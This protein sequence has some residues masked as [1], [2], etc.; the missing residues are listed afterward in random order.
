MRQEEFVYQKISEDFS[1]VM[2]C[3]STML[4]ELG[5]TDLAQQMR[6]HQQRLDPEADFHLDRTA[7]AYS[8]AFQLLSMVEENAQSQYRRVAETH[9]EY[10][11]ESGLWRRILISLKEAGLTGEQIATRLPYLWVEPVLTAHPTEAK[12]PTVLDHHREF[13]L[14]LLRRENQMWTPSEQ[15][16]I[17]EEIITI[18][19]RLWRTGEIYLEKPRLEQELDNILHYLRNVFPNILPTLDQRLREAW[20]E[21]GFDPALLDDPS[22]FPRLSFGNWVGGDRDGHPLVTAEVTEIC[23]KRLRTTALELLQQQLET[24]RNTLSLAEHRQPVPTILQQRITELQNALGRRG[25]KVVY[26]FRREPWRQLVELFC[27]ALPESSARGN[28]SEFSYQRSQDLL[29]DLRLLRESLLEVGAGRMARQEVDPVI[30]L[31]QTFGFHLAVLDI[32]QNSSFHDQAIEQLLETAGFADTSFGIW[33]EE[34]RLNFLEQELKTHRPFALSTTP[35]GP[36]ATAIRECYGVLRQYMEAH[37]EQGIGNFIVSMTRSATDLLS[38]Y[39]LANEA[40]LLRQT[41]DGLICPIHIV[42]LFETI[43]DLIASPTIMQRFLA[44]PLT[45]RSLRYQQQ[46]TGWDRPTQQIMVG[47]SDSNKDGGILASQWS[48]FRAQEKLLEIGQAHGISLRFF[49][50]RGGTISRGAGPTHRFLRALPHGSIGGNLRL[51]EQGE[52]I[53]QKYANLGTAHYQLEMLVAGTAGSSLLQENQPRL[54][55]PMEGVM[56]DLMESSRQAYRQLLEADG[57][58][59]FFREATPIDVI[60]SSRIGSR[61]S[62]R[63]GQRSLSDLRAIPWVF[64]WSQSRFFLSSWY[65]LGTAL[66]QLREAQPEVFGRLCEENLSWHPFHYLTSNVATSLAMV[67]EDVTAQYAKLV[68]NAEVRNRLLLQILTE[69]RRSRSMLEVLYAGPLEE[70]RARIQKSIEL[71]RNGLRSLHRQQLDLLPK[72][73]GLKAEGYDEE[74]EKLL[75]P[76]LIT[77]NAIASGLRTTG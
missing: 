71:R 69:Y 8:I 16:R 28:R 3:F 73:R 47:Y 61:P 17:R 55:N 38:V 64:A 58:I 72:W 66:S 41:E 70:R 77:V 60:E 65:G 40:G 23:L 50:G 48:L 76:L 31:V 26:R 20:R 32:R 1:F 15:E 19:E 42:P 36:Q 22:H 54:H 53:A 44:D 43:D 4:D 25:D 39:L 59:D 62:R 75:V 74:A 12:R 67:D 14:L 13:Y 18:L 9:P 51:T 5:E 57:F 24:L 2:D 27:K 68:V 11:Q 37:G 52:T 49:H 7:Q 30:R 56:D 29:Q 45:Q 6:A 63:S 35:I 21:V 10:E 34:A 46:A 33:S